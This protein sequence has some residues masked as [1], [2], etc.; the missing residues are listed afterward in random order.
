MRT[1][2]QLFLKGVFSRWWVWVVGAPSGL[3]TFLDLYVPR[4][5]LIQD[6]L[7]D[8]LPALGATIFIGALFV[9]AFLTYH[10]V[11]AAI[12]KDYDA[13]I[14]DRLYELYKRGHT[15]AGPAGFI[16]L[17]VAGGPEVLRRWVQ[18]VERFLGQHLPGELRMFQTIDDEEE[19]SL[20]GAKEDIT[21]PS[22]LQ[23]KVKK[24]RLIMGRYEARR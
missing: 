17:T 1:S 20:F 2:L 7:G 8:L 24:L 19:H 10:E 9:A 5:V 13:A 14:G 22:Q 11:R 18:D 15:L 16:R 12:P 6:R 3:I 21:R 4:S 23:P